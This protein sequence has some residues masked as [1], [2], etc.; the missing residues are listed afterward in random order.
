MKLPKIPSKK[1]KL[2]T[3]LRII[4]GIVIYAIFYPYISQTILSGFK[5][6]IGENGLLE[7]ILN[8]MLI[9]PFV[10]SS[11]HFLCEGILEFNSFYDK[12]DNK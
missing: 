11:F 1:E 10:Q 9:L 2:R 6:I 12:H 3:T 4:I 8:T 5:N 7:T